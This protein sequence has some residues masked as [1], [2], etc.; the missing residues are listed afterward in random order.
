MRVKH[1]LKLTLKLAPLVSSNGA[2]LQPSR[3][4]ALGD[5]IS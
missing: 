3:G 5:D 4:D 2:D 1:L